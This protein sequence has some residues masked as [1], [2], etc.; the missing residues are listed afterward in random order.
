MG[1]LRLM[2]LIATKAFTDSLIDA[3]QWKT[4]A[5]EGAHFSGERDAER[6]IEYAKGFASKALKNLFS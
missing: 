6:A 4:D 3:G 5:T 2:N 1:T